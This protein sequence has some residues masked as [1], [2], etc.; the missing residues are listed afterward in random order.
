VVVMMMMMMMMMMPS[1]C[2]YDSS[3]STIA[4]MVMMVVSV[5][6]D[7]KRPIQGG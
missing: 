4:M 2:N 3:F 1:G 7:P 6:G 5:L